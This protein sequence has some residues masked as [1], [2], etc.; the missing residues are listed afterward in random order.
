MSTENF[1]VERVVKV[2]VPS[3]VQSNFEVLVG[4]WAIGF[5]FRRKNARL[6]HILRI[7]YATEQFSGLL[8]ILVRSVQCLSVNCFW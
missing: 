4:F 5:N 2:L 6:G 3:V 1:A 7:S 8:G